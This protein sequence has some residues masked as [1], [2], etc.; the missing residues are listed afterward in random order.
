MTTTTEITIMRSLKN[1]GKELWARIYHVVELECAPSN[2]M[3][4]A[5]Q[6]QRLSLKGEFWERSSA[7]ALFAVNRSS[8]RFGRYQYLKNL[9]CDRRAPF[10]EYPPVSM[11]DGTIADNNSSFGK[12]LQPFSESHVESAVCQIEIP[13]M[14]TVLFQKNESTW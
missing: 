2:R 13:Q 14:R 7:Q 12:L 3:T 10:N 9:R 5:R 11:F 1:W 4:A 6:L 8:L